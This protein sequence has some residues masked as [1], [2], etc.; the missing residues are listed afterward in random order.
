MVLGSIGAAI[1]A[2][3]GGVHDAWK[4]HSCVWEDEETMGIVA[5]VVSGSAP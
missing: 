2:R 5:G 3:I 1:G 4:S